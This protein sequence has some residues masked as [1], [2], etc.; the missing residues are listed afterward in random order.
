MASVT[1]FLSQKLALEAIAA[2]EFDVHGWTMNGDKQNA[3]TGL[4]ELGRKNNYVV[5]QPSAPGGS[6]NA[7]HYPKVYDFLNKILKLGI[8]K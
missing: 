3:N 7:S 1:M 6:W 5:V 2:L 4:A 8:L